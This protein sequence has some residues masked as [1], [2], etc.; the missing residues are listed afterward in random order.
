MD[1]F[2]ENKRSLVGYLFLSLAIPLGNLALPHYYGKIVDQISKDGNLTDA[3][4][5]NF[6]IVFVLWVVVQ[7]LWAMMSW[8]DSYFMPAIQ[9]YVRKY[10]VQRV[11]DTYKERYQE[12]EVGKLI[13][14]IIKLPNV[15]KNFIY[16]VR[17]QMLP[18][19]AVLLVSVAYFF[20]IDTGLGLVGLATISTFFISMY[21]FSNSCLKYSMKMNDEY[22]NLHED[23][24]D[25]L[26]NLVNVYTSSECDEEI[27]RFIKQQ[28]LFNE[29]Y[30]NAIRC[31]S[32]F[33]F[34]FN[35]TFLLVF[36]G[37][38]GYAFHLLFNKKI[39]LPQIVSVLVISLYLITEMTHLTN[40]IDAVAYNLGTIQ[41]IQDSLDKVQG[42]K[43]GGTEKFEVK[44]DI[45]YENI[46]VHHANIDGL[47]LRIPEGQKV[48]LVGKIGSGKSTLINILLRLIPFDGNIKI[49]D[50][51]TK[52][53]DIDHLR[54]SIIY[55]PQQ[56]KLFNRTVY[57]N[58]AYGNGASR[59]DVKTVFE[60]YNVPFDLDYK[61]GKGGE[62]LSGGQ[63][64]LLYLLRCLFRKSN[65]I[66]LDEPTNNLDEESKRYIMGILS[67]LMKDKTAIIVTHDPDVLK[68]V[69]RI[70]EMKNGSIV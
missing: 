2:R 7:S 14:Q 59:E 55:A 38:N 44:G 51:D 30:K 5:K 27:E 39:Q 34:F 68:Y 46:K 18:V 3:M 21:I 43:S 22:N 65:I 9:G 63:R 58:V 4:K 49:G 8:I 70:V 53:F 29:Q 54:R 16:Q 12:Q 24:S 45:S 50:E 52:K 48:G 35:F 28:D 60:K 40:E 64:Q 32:K 11:L 47:N 10:L 57:E 62:N 66:V 17:N 33:R 19:I 6:F 37:V 15:L 36:F 25:T 41:Q 31:S 20:Y 56:A 61:V 26:L 69:D 67:E 1:F 23:I 42:H 13:A